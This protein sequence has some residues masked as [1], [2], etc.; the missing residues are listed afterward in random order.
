MVS[1]KSSPESSW[2][3]DQAIDVLLS[4]T[5]CQAGLWLGARG[6]DSQNPPLSTPCCHAPH[7]KKH[8]DDPADGDTCCAKGTQQF[9]LWM[10]S[11]PVLHFYQMYPVS[12]PLVQLWIRI[13]LQTSPVKQSHSKLVFF[14]YA[15][16]GNL[17]INTLTEELYILMLLLNALTKSFYHLCSLLSLIP[18]AALASSHT[19]KMS[20]KHVCCQGSWSKVKDRML[21]HSGNCCVFK[22]KRGID[23]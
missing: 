6:A 21:L 22:N 15:K 2:K 10:G 9:P 20:S 1:C 11:N 16:C 14:T 12:W 7:S 19:S 23:I 8:E 4:S 17:V 18:C 5:V 3:P 13:L